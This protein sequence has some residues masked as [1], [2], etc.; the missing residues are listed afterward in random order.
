MTSKQSIHWGLE[1]TITVKRNGNPIGVMSGHNSAT[2]EGIREILS[3]VILGDQDFDPGQFYIGLIDNIGFTTVSR[4]DKLPALTEAAGWE[5][6]TSY[7]LIGR[8]ATERIRV[9]AV[10]TGGAYGSL[11]VS[12]RSSPF[13]PNVIRITSPTA[14]L[15]GFFI[16]NGS[17]KGA[18][19]KLYGAGG[20]NAN[21]IEIE[22]QIGDELHCEFRYTLI[23][24]LTDDV[25]VTGQGGLDL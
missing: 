22:V 1:A 18:G 12:L 20:L 23:S 2:I 7:N 3:Y 4:D 25:T 9:T 11:R 8:P 19:G 15:A 13:N 14:V 5:E 10:F 24:D 16:T 6:F 21:S 17:T